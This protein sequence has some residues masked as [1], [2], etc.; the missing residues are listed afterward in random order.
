MAEGVTIL[1]V[2]DDR[3]TRYLL[4]KMLAKGGYRVV[5]AENGA[6]ALRLAHAERQPDLVILDIR[7][8]DINGLEV[9]RRLKGDPTTAMIPVLQTSATFMSSTRKIEGLDSG[10]DAYLAQPIDE[11]ELLATVQALLRARRAED[12]VS[13]AA[14][15]WQATFDAIGDGIVIVDAAGA[16]VSCNRAMARLVGQAADNVVGRPATWSLGRLLAPATLEVLWAPGV[17]ARAVRTGQSAEI[18]GAG[19]VG[20][21]PLVHATAAGHRAPAH[22][23]ATHH[24]APRAPCLRVHRAAPPRERRAA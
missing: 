12:A 4:G 17:Q 23:P 9:C 2:N 3:A 5:D 7:L 14:Q 10:A 21:H 19:L 6:E 15:R 11:L 8:P 13:R 24:D 20:L 18:A 22:P 1:N 16:V